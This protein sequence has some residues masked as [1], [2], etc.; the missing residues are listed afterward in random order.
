MRLLQLQSATSFCVSLIP[1]Q[2]ES[3]YVWNGQPLLSIKVWSDRDQKGHVWKLGS[4]WWRCDMW[5]NTKEKRRR[6]GRKLL[7]AFNFVPP[8]ELACPPTEL[9]CPPTEL[10]CRSSEISQ[11]KARF[12]FDCYHGQVVVLPNYVTIKCA[13]QWN[14][15]IMHAAICKSNLND[16]LQLQP[17]YTQLYPWYI[18]PLLKYQWNWT[19][20]LSRETPPRNPV[21]PLYHLATF[22]V[23]S[24][25]SFGKKRKAEAVRLKASWKPGERCSGGLSWQSTGT[26]PKP[27]PR[28]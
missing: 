25:R 21:V 9:A 28:I 6:E 3:G 14:L 16:I 10:A 24:Q 11:S 1:V 23:A 17:Y 7:P 26:P 12:F 27:P 4:V 5:K 20:S 2:P 19:I 18:I 13:S 15:H 8:T 22:Q